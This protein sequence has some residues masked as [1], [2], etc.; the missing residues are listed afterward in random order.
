[1]LAGVCESVAQAPGGG[2]GTRRSAGF[3]D[4]RFSE[5][6]SPT[7]NRR[8]GLTS[9]RRPMLT[10]RKRDKLTILIKKR[11]WDTGQCSTPVRP[12]SWS[13]FNAC[14]QPPVRASLHGACGLPHTMNSSPTGEK[15]PTVVLSGAKLLGGGQHLQSRADTRARVLHCTAIACSSSCV[16]P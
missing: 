9:L 12:R 14:S 16:G 4:S 3:Q 8:R 13:H 11:L 1:M 6:H 15:R 7:V 10:M 5:S 2:L